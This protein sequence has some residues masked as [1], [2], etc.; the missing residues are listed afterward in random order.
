MFPL[1]EVRA[2]GLPDASDWESKAS[3]L[4]RAAAIDTDPTTGQDLAFGFRQLV[5]IAERALS[6]SVNDPTTASQCIDVLHDLLRRLAPHPLPDGLCRDDHGT[7]RLVVPQY[8]SADYLEVAL[9]EI[10]HYGSESAQ[11]PP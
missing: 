11:I 6:P 3:H 8:S 1:Y 5:D 4:V 7:V 2:A 9:S 10:W